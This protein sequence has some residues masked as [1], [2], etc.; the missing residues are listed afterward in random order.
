MDEKKAATLPSNEDGDSSWVYGAIPKDA[1]W[2]NDAFDQ[3][4]AR[5]ETTPELVQFDED[6]SERLEKSR[7]FEKTVGHDPETFDAELEQR[8]HCMKQANLL[9]RLAI[10]NKE[11][12]ACVRD[13]RTGETLQLHSGGWVHDK[14]N[15]YIPAAIWQPFVDTGDIELPGPEGTV[16]EG[17]H[18]PVF[19]M[20][21]ELQVWLGALLRNKLSAAT[22][23]V[24]VLSRDH[25]KKAAREI[26]LRLLRSE[27]DWGQCGLPKQ[28]ERMKLELK[29]VGE[30]GCSERLLVK[31]RREI[32]CKQI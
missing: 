16:I 15:D 30:I 18:L 26:Y 9:L 12:I 23:A 2:L 1:I 10:E 17:K 24:K 4:L 5:I 22:S 6:W 11:L 31:I 19:F 32:K 8:W 28:L 25:K 21:V 20:Q 14:W 7:Q 27:K 13:P 3:V 29:A